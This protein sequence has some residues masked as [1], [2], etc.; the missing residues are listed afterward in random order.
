MLV[1]KQCFRMNSMRCLSTSAMRLKLI[2]LS[3]DDKTGIATLEMNRPPVNS[4]NTPL[5][6]DISS[7]LTELS[8]NKS[9]GL[10]LTS[11]CSLSTVLC[12]I[13]KKLNHSILLFLVIIIGIL[14]RF[15]YNGN[16]QTRS[17]ENKSILD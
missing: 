12:Q 3:V 13:K 2:N 10:I 17:R 4:L 9:K 16:V 6:Q 7:A 5:L 8:K 1:A 14:S 11:V 15:G